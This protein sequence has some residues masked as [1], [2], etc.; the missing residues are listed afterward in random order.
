MPSL[1]MVVQTLKV[2]ILPLDLPCSGP[3]TNS[4]EILT[5]G[6]SHR[7]KSDRFSLNDDTDVKKVLRFKYATWNIRGLG[8]KEELDK[9]LN[10]NNIKIS[11]ITESKKKL[12][13]TKETEYYTA[14]YSGV[15]RHISG[16]SGVMIW[17]H[18]SISNKI[19]HH[20]FWNDR[21]TETRLKTQRGH[22]TILGVYGPAEGRDELNEECY[23]T[24]QTLLDKVNKN[25]YIMLIGDMNSRVGNNRV[26][27]IVG[28]NGEATLNSNGRK[29]IDFCT[30]NNLKIMNKFFKHEEINKFT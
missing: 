18:K 2:A 5:P 22:L 27:N 12:Q 7:K 23:E 1:H 20:K 14:I 19:D 15:D 29:L 6:K 8:Q 3:V 17:I 28:T 4:G 13:G 10:E 25:D 21:V 30:F 26:A 16:Q 9:I 24:L 11:V